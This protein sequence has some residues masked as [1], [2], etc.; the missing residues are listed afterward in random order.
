ME[1]QAAS[2]TPHAASKGKKPKAEYNAYAFSLQKIST[3]NK[4][5][6]NISMWGFIKINT[7]IIGLKSSFF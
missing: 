5:N 2:Y 7:I 1:R 4:K 6:P 3:L